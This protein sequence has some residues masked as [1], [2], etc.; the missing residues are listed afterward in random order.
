MGG[1]DLSVLPESIDYEHVREVLRKKQEESKNFVLTALKKAEQ[2]ISENRQKDTA[3]YEA[4]RR[5]LTYPINYHSGKAGASHSYDTR[6]Q[7]AKISS[8]AS[9]AIEY[10]Q[11][12]R[13]YKNDGT[14][15]LEKNRFSLE[16][17]KFTGWTIRLKID[18]HWFWYLSDGS[19]APAKDFAEYRKQ[20]G[21]SKMLLPDEGILPT[22]PVNR[23]R[24]M[25]A[26]AN[27]ERKGVSLLYKIKRRILR[28]F[29]K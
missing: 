3:R 14:S 19:L 16:G 15:H 13:L 24:H 25:V 5:S 21:C 6:Q 28:K 7:G 10:S 1:G 23:I 11:A 26:E 29:S 20:T 8:F 9:G 18:N 22:I 27:W 12:D 17:H 2:R 4:H